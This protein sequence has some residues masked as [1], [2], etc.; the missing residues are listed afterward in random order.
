MCAV[1]T[2]KIN[3]ISSRTYTMVGPDEEIETLVFVDDILSMGTA[4]NMAKT[5]QN[6]MMLEQT[7]KFT[8]SVDKELIT[9]L[10]EV[11]KSTPYW[12]IIEETAIWP[13]LQTIDFQKLMLLHNMLNSEDTKIS[14]KVLLSQARNQY[15]NC[16]Y[17]E[18]LQAA[19]DYQLDIS[20]KWLQKIRKSDWKKEVKENV[21]KRI[22]KRMEEIK[23]QM[24]KLRF[25]DTSF[26]QESYITNT[27][28]DMCR[29][30]MRVRL[31]MTKLK[32]NYKG[33]GK[34][35]LCTA[36]KAEEETTEHVFNCTAYRRALE[37]KVQVD[38]TRES[39]L[40]SKLKEASVF[41]NE[42]EQYKDKMGIG[43]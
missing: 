29:I 43:I 42:L 25:I 33:L 28:A 24:T 13:I 1:V 16:W 31:N 3:A 34:D 14:K 12:G 36:C 32:S 17:S 22:R 11:A 2:D 26:V 6:L 27:T 8:F 38:I 37:S 23:R 7:K 20:T 41:A 30:I 10:F 40:S 21:T 18:I 4:D 19:D 15:P 35:V 5:E 9:L 39:R